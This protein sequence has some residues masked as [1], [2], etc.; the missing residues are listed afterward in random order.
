MTKRSKSSGDDPIKPTK[1]D[2]QRVRVN[3][4]GY[5]ASG[6]YWGAGPDVFIATTLDGTEE[7]TVRAR[8]VSDARDKVA[9]ELARQP[10]TPRL[11]AEPIGG[12][13]PRKT[14]YEIN[15]RNPVTAETVRIRITHARD[16][17]VQGTDHI[18]VESIMPKKAPL[19]ITATGYLSHFIAPLQLINAGGP[20]TFVTAW[21]DN[22]ARGKAWK[23]QAATTAQGDLFQWAD[24]HK[25]IGAR[26]KAKSQPSKPAP[27]QRKKP[28]RS[29]APE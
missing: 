3:A 8:N 20:V 10:G 16:Y 27:A 15:W 2:I 18:E 29:R 22:E 28:T 12:A 4:Q 11:M 6:A 14:K 25:E 7:V 26:K 19:P 13:A 1:L 5:D 21:I 24:A 23:K 9:A 17:L